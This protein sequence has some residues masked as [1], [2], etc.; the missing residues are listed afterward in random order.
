MD[1]STIVWILI[2]V[3]LVAII[4]GAIVAMQRRK[5]AEQHREQAAVLRQEAIQ[6]AP[7]VDRARAEA[8]AAERRAAE[9]RQAHAQAAAQQEDQ[10]RTADRVDPDVDHR[11]QAY[12]PTTPAGPAAPEQGTPQA[13]EPTTTPPTGGQ[14]QATLPGEGQQTPASTT[15]RSSTSSTEEGWD[16]S[17][18]QQPSS[19]APTEQGSTYGQGTHRRE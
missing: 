5:R 11:S 12:E 7:E 4:A 13:A 15:E 16:G 18:G 9:A 6:K 3:A 8:V 17:T 2:I 14:H 1:T 19:E 10:L